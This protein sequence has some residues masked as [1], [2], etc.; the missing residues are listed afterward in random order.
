M[1]YIIG[2][3]EFCKK[4]SDWLEFGKQPEAEW[5]FKN[6]SKIPE[7][8]R[9]YNK[10]LYRGMTVSEEFVDSINSPSGLIIKNFA[11]WTKNKNLAIKFATGSTGGVYRSGDIKILL[12]KS[13]PVS[14]QVIDIHSYVLFMGEKPLELLG[15]DEL[16]LDSAFKEEEVLIAKNLRLMKSDV[17]IL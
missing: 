3:P 8:F 6:R 17:T 12:K 10:P 16:C 5:L 13:I 15:V 1:E 9:K 11:S 7:M 14:Y 2:T 4:V